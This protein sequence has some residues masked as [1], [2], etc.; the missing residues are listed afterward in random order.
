MSEPT[1]E[2]QERRESRPPFEIRI[3]SYRSGDK[4]FCKVDNVSPGACVAR[5][6]GATREEAEAAAIA[7]ADKA[8]KATRVLG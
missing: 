1:N 3:S 6:E 2:Y 8:L 5:G 7:E 4:F